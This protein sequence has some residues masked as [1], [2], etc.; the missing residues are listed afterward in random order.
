MCVCVCVC[1]CEIRVNADFK[2]YHKDEI[3]NIYY[4]CDFDVLR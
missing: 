4:T 1:V 2:R 3:E